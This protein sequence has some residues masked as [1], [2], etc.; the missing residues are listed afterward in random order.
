MDF[1]VMAPAQ[2]NREL[3]ADFAAQSRVLRE[4]QMVG[5]RRLPAADEARLPGHVLDMIPVADPAWFGE[6]EGA[7]VDR[8]RN[9]LGPRPL[10][11]SW[12]LCV[13]KVPGW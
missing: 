5:I 6:G 10:A 7:F 8:P 12:C 2:G 1:A 4:P 13:G 3:I 9:P 11:G